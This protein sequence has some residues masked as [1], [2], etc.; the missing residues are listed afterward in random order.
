M[1]LF[2]LAFLLVGACLGPASLGGQ[3]GEDLVD[4]A[5]DGDTAGTDTGGPDTDSDDT[6]VDTADSG[7][8]S[9]TDSVDARF[10]GPFVIDV[11]HAEGAD[12]C[13]G[14]ITLTLEGTA[15]NGTA[16]C[17]FDNALAETFPAGLEAIVQGDA[18]A[19]ATAGTLTF[20]TGVVGELA[21]TG[22]TTELAVT[23]TFDGTIGDESPLA[24]NGRF[25]AAKE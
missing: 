10:T 2:F 12:T 6:D 7:T 13:T 25:D 5:T 19:D 14:T 20:V 24:M 22:I 16:S 15:L 17:T 3:E 9:G 23:G 21:W 4:T 11:I 18:G 1:R 8:D